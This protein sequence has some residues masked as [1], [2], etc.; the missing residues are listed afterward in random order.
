MSDIRKLAN[1]TPA[2]TKGVEALAREA[3]AFLGPEWIDG[4]AQTAPSRRIRRHVP[5]YDK[6]LAGSLTALDIGLRTLRDRCPHFGQW[7]DWLEGLSAT[8]A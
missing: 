5:R 4:G 1:Y 3:D 6:V 7:I 2:A 8:E